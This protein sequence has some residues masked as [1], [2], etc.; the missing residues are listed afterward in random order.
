MPPAELKAGGAILGAFRPL[1]PDID[2]CTAGGTVELVDVAS[3]VAG[4][5][6]GRGR[7]GGPS[8]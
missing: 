3:A 2:T 5:A 7:Y 4:D 1:V 8:F 6:M